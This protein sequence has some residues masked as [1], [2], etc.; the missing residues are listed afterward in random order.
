[1]TNLVWT[2]KEAAAKIR[3]EGLRLDVRH[4]VVAP[5]DA[6][7][8]T[9]RIARCESTGPDAVAPTSGWRRA[10]GGWVMT[11]AGEPAPS[12]PTGAP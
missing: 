3:R 12:R 8:A 2:A 7:A 1:M 10:G 11:I 6:G 5:A 9:A 4:A